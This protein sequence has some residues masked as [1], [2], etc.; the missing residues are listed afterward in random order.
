MNNNQEK[1]YYRAELVRF[2]L[3]KQRHTEF[4]NELQ[5]KMKRYLFK[6][7][8]Q[9]KTYLRKQILEKKWQ[10]ENCDKYIKIYSEHLQI[11]N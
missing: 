11:L 1:E 9:E 8:S 10:I 3:A 6:F 5:I 7:C 2:T 4:L